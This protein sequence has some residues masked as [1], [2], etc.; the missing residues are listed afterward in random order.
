MNEVLNRLPH[1]DPFLFVDTIVDQTEKHIVAQKQLT[2][3]E[4]FF[5]G[6]FPGNPVMPG[7]LLLEALFQAGALLMSSQGG[8]Q[9]KTPVVSRVEKTKFKRMAKPGDL[10]ILEVELKEQLGNA[11]YMRG[12][13]HVNDKVIA[14]SEFACNLL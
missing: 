10:L 2:G 9:N 8:L 6:H 3:R 13:V 14:S 7:V 1:R 11:W 5:Q 4:D 12:K